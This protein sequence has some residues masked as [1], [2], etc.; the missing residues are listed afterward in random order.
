MPL[1]A[2][3]IHV[4]LIDFLLTE[5]FGEDVHAVEGIAFPA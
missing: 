3:I 2:A 4:V 1:T 5:G